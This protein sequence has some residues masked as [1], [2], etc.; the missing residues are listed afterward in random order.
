MTTSAAQAATFYSEALA[1]GTV[2][3]VRDV[4]GFPAPVN[5]DGVRAMP[6]WSTRS[7]AERVLANVAA[8][9]GFEPVEVPLDKWR[10]DWLTGLDRDGLMVGLNWAG[11]RAQ[12]YDVA[13][14]DVLRTLS[15]REAASE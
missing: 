9:A 7:R 14:A 12:G 6:F 1:S 8:Y 10:T 2:W 3:G 15:A 11:D 13:P 5:G 4:N